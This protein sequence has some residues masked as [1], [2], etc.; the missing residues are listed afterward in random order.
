MACNRD[1]FTFTLQFMCFWLG[2]LMV[3]SVARLYSVRCRMKDEL[4]GI[5]N[6]VVMASWDTV[7]EF[8]WGGTAGNHKKP[9]SRLPV[10]WPRFE[11]GTSWTIHVMKS[12]VFYIVLL[13]SLE[14]M[15]RAMY[16]YPSAQIVCPVSCAWTCPL[17]CN[18]VYTFCGQSG[19]PLCK[20]T[21]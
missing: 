5:W 18:P 10:P 16:T 14:S 12:A 13:Y 2:Y 7:S 9:K 1:I 17:K 19:W 21:N 20:D 3:M 11:L 15:V 4:A 8:A 6:E